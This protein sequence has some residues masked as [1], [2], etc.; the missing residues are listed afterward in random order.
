MNVSVMVNFKN[1]ELPLKPKFDFFHSSLLSFLHYSL[2]SFVSS[3]QLAKLASTILYF[4]IQTTFT[5]S[6]LMS[7]YYNNQ[8][9]NTTFSKKPSSARLLWLIT[10]NLLLVTQAPLSQTKGKKKGFC[11][12]FKKQNKKVLYSYKTGDW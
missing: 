6:P 2:F 7:Y 4:F 12:C 10:N 1:E 8:I 3:V 11:W 9:N 5:S